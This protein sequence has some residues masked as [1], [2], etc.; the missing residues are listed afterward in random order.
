MAGLGSGPDREN[1]A[2]SGRVEWEFAQMDF[3]SRYRA[4]PAAATLL[5]LQVNVSEAE[6]LREDVTAAWPVASHA[7]RVNPIRCVARR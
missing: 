3:I 6:R 4:F 1:T 5:L 2:R 7:A